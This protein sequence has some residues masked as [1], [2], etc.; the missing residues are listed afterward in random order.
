[1]KRF[2][3]IVFMFVTAAGFSQQNVIKLGL[4]GMSYGMYSLSYERQIT[5]KSSLNLLLGYWNVN[6]GL[7]SNDSLEIGDGFGISSYKYGFNSEIDYRFYVGGQGG[8]KGLYIG[9]Y[10]RYWNYSAVLYDEINGVNFDVNSNVSS[11]GMGFQMGYHWIIN[12]KF[13][14]D[15]YFVG[16]GLERMNINIEYIAKVPGYTYTGSQDIQDDIKNVFND[17][18]YLYKRI[19][20]ESIPNK[21]ATAKLPFFSPGIKTGFSIGYA[22]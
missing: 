8:I 14:I 19:K 13:S 6:A 10:A 4:S 11:I 5:P 3:I 16:L 7:L 20:T 9:P 12:N 18:D 1:M 22:F 21:N 2:L 15:W 17:F